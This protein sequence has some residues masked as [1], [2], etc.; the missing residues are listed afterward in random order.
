MVIEDACHALGAKY[1]GPDINE[2]RQNEYGRFD[3]WTQIGSCTYSDMTV[4]SFHPVKHIAT[5]EG[6]AV[7]TKNER[8]YDKLLMFRSHGIT[9]NRL[10]FVDSGN[11]DQG[12]WYYEMQF[13]G[14]NYR[15]S[16]I[17]AALGYSQLAKIER[18][19]KARR[20]IA[21]Y[22]NGA[23]Q[24][25]QHFDIPIE[26]TYCQSA[27]HLYTIRL[28]D[29]LVKSKT[30]IFRKLR[31]AGLGVQVLYIPVYLQPYYRKLGYLEGSCPV[32][33]NF[34]R[35]A[36]SIPIYHDMTHGDPEKVASR[37]LAV[38]EEVDK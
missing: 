37:V 9:K 13:L 35:R 23:F 5:G 21:A 2:K 38:M 33:E 1:G 26:R 12:E 30:L 8:I 31:E 19:V 7:L 10:N 11:T 18:F 15:M 29:H 34:Y 32:A 14:F 4:M 6:G 20:D 25:N 27:Y 24:N 3:K 17:Q 28:K 36:I 16:D 22:Y